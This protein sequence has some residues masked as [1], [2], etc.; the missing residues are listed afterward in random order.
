M[1]AVTSY[2]ENTQLASPDGILKTGMIPVS[3]KCLSPR[4]GVRTRKYNDRKKVIDVTVSFENEGSIMVKDLPTDS[5]ANDLCVRIRDIL[6]LRNDELYS[7]YV[8]VCFFQR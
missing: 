1:A 6:N 7:I 4:N 2:H 8:K 5:T 3:H